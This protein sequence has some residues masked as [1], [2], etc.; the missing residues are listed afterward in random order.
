MIEYTKCSLSEM[1][2]LNYDNTR[3]LIDLDAV[4]HNIDAVRQK[5]GVPVMAVIKADAY[6]HG[7]VPIAHLLRDKCAFFGV[8][9]MLEALELRRAGIDNPILILGHTPPAAFPEAVRLGIRPA[10]F[11][12]DDALALSRAAVEA[13]V[14]APFHFALDTGMSRIGFQASEESADTCVKI[15]ALPG[16]RAEG[17]F[18]HFATADSADLTRSRRQAALFDAFDAMLRVRGVEIPIRHLDNSAGLMNFPC[19]YEMVRS[20][21]VTYGMYPSDEVS[22]TLLPLEPALQWV[23]RITHL[24]L[25]PAGREISYGGTFVT[26]RPTLVAT[27]PV[28]YADGYRRSLSG[29]FHVLIRGAKA[30]ILGRVC[31]DQ[32]MVDVTHIPGAALD[33]PVVLVGRSGEA[34][35]TVEDIAAAADSFNYE[36]VCGISRRVPRVYTAAGKPVHSVHY[37]LDDQWQTH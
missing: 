7:A 5:A 34:R 17:L 20:G 36:F 27:I 18:S 6:G 14:T 23:S 11:R 32:L 12:Y 2:D 25:L 28:G 29:K 13:G 4:S 26:S 16:L 37:L 31:M 9:S 35:I 3:V 8:S 21:I 30:P 33:D 15:A 1:I 10:I 22:P 24:K 19:R